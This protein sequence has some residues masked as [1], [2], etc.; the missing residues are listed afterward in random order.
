MHSMEESVLV[1]IFIVVIGAVLSSF[2]KA[3]KQKAANQR[4]QT[5]SQP[6]P[7]EPVQQP[8]AM[9]PPRPAQ[10]T[11]QSTLRVTEH[12][13]TDMFAGSLNADDSG[14]GR[15]DHDHGFTGEVDMPSMHSDQE[16]NRSLTE[17]EQAEDGDSFQLP[18]TPQG[19]VQSLVMQ[20]VL[21]RPCQR[22]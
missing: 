7:S 1:W 5:V 12:D 21:R 3:A 16:L 15:D 13:H 10:P 4:P 17:E 22:R 18:L 20:E 14:E 9:L 6:A 2:S 8:A 11:L 19:L